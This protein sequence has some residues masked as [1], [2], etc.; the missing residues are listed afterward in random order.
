MRV[1]IINGASEARDTVL[2][3]Y[4]FQDMPVSPSLRQFLQRV[5]GKPLSP[6]QAVDEIIREVSDKG[7][8]ALFR[9]SSLTDGVK[10]S[11]LEVPREKIDRAYSTIPEQLRQALE[12]AEQ[13]IRVFHEKQR[14]SSWLHWSD[15]GAVG[16]MIR[17]LER[18]GLYVPGGRAPLASSLLMAAVPA[19]VA[20]V[21]T[22]VVCS[23]PNRKTGLPH[24]VVLAAAKVAGVTKVFAVGGAQAIAAMAI[25]TETVPRVDKVLGAGALLTVL[26]KKTLFGTVGIESLPGPTETLIIADSTADARLVAADMLAQAEHDPMASA[27]LL[28][29]CKDLAMDV[30]A[31]L[32]AQL[33]QA[34]RKEVAAQAIASNGGIVLVHDVDEA[35]ALANEYAPEHLCLLTA[36]PWQLLPRVKNAGGVFVGESSSEALGDYIIGPSHIMPTGG[37]ARFASPVNVWDFV[38]I[39]SVFAPGP[40]DIAALSSHAAVLAEAEGLTGHRDA[41]LLRT[42]PRT[43]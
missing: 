20:G 41:I 24:D 38:K 30:Q 14:V 4:S 43:K 22:I 5:F 18:V 31:E 36:N 10:L 42:R 16:Q 29:P 1:R 40:S 39:T 3:R 13:R 33:H 28:T 34:S 19:S 7:D 6:Q 27:I 23:P 17:P 25:G 21:S 15:D 12:V 35:M 37:T 11:S 9:L 2:K 26:A 32:E 8:D